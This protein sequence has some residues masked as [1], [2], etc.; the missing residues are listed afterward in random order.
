MTTFTEGARSAEGLMYHIA[1][2]SLDPVTY[3]SGNSIASMQ[4]VK[5]TDAATVPAVAADTSGLYLAY[6]AYDATSAAVKG[7]AIKRHAVVNGNLIA[8]PSGAT[9]PQ[10][11]AIDAAL[12][13]VG[14]V[15]RR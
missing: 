10:K 7:V 5:G 1:D 14:I 11:A 3:S 15:V 12:L 8:Y 2:Y 4:V 6:K 13:A 9:T